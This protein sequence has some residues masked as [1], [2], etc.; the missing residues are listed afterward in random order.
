[1]RFQEVSLPNWRPQVADCHANV[2][3]WVEANPGTVAVRGWVTYADFGLS[4]GLTA[5]SVVREP[6]GQ[7]FDITPLESK[8]VRPTMRFVPHVGDEQEFLT[9][10]ES[11]A[12]IECPCG[13]DVFS[14][15]QKIPAM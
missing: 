9:M 2:D 8:G 7:L 6:D 11:K 12:F 10:R 5:H 4:I 3:K 14:A 15:N 13:A 1:M